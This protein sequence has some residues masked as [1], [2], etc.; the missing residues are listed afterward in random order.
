MVC[1]RPW[2]PHLTE[3]DTDESGHVV[4]VEVP[5]VHGVDLPLC[6]LEHARSHALGDVLD[7]HT[8]LFIQVEEA[9][10]DTVKILQQ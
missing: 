4:T 2:R 5:I 9:G 3:S 6:K 10:N 1:V 7:D 8:I